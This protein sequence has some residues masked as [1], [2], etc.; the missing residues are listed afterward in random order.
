MQA[1]LDREWP[2]LLEGEDLIEPTDELLWRQINPR[3][4]HDGIIGELAFR[5]REEEQFQLS[6]SRSSKVS[7]QQAYEHHT[8]VVGRESAGVAALSAIEVYETG[9]RAV[10]DFETQTSEPP[11]PAHAYVDCRLMTKAERKDFREECA[12]V[13]TDRGLVYQ[14]E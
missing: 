7:A 11:T 9:S 8:C 13:A 3:F 2:P 4:F 6:V 5:A 10:D 12:A 1:E 14:P